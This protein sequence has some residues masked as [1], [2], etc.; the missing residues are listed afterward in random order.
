LKSIIL[1]SISGIIY[2]AIIIS[3]LILG[4]YSSGALI[5][6]LNFFALTEFYKLTNNN[7]N[8]YQVYAFS[9]TGTLAA[10]V[11]ILYMLSLVTFKVAA[12]S[13]V[14]MPFFLILA[15]FSKQLD[16]IKDVSLKTLGIL[17]ITLPL[18]TLFL[19]LFP[20]GRDTEYNYKIVLGIL[21][22]IWTNDTAA[23]ITG[24]SFGKHR[25]FERISPKKSWEGAIGGTVFTLILAWFMPLLMGIIT[26]AGWLI[27]AAIISVF[28]VLGDLAESMLKRNGSVK[29]SG[30]LIP[31][32]GGI[33]DRIDSMLFVF[34][35]TWLYLYLIGFVKL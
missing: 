28:G 34:P 5:I 27:I 29:D 7:V 24:M 16:P 18:L 12:L 2:L 21:I 15:M 14:L 4:K 9:I 20:G 11:F 6:L 10:A 1:R 23:Y 35:I 8:S 17:Y 22:L 33:L 31:G 25:L 32:H 13:L 3:A 26:N 30:K 19:I